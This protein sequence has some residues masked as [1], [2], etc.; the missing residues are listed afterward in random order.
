MSVNVAFDGNT[1]PVPNQPGE[2][3]WANLTAYLVALG[4]SAAT[5][6]A[7]LQAVRVATT[8]PVT[9]TATD[10]SIITNLTVA[11]AVAVDLP[12]GVTKQLI[13]IVDGKGD[14]QAN[15]VTITGNGGQQING[16]ANHVLNVNRGGV[17]LQFDGTQWRILAAFYGSTP[18]FTSITITSLNVTG[19]STL[20]AVDATSINIGGVSAATTANVS[21]A[22]TAHLSDPDPHSQYSTTAETSTAVAAGISAH[23]GASDPHPQYTTASEAAAAAPVQSVATRTGNVTLDKNDV[24]LSNVD[25]TSDATKNSATA[26]LSNKTL[27]S[28]TVNTPVLGSFEDWTHTTTP[29]N[30]SAGRLRAY[31]K[32]DGKPYVL[33]S[34]GVEKALLRA[35]DGG[36]GDVVGPSSTDDNAVVVW[37]GTTGKL[38]K[39]VTNGAF[40]FANTFQQTAPSGAAAA[41]DARSGA[42]RSYFGYVDASSGRGFIGNSDG[43]LTANNVFSIGFGAITDGIFAEEALQANSLG[44]VRLGKL[45]SIGGNTFP[46]HRFV[47]GTDST[48]PGVGYVDEY[49]EQPITSG[50]NNT[51]AAFGTQDS[52][53]FITL[54]AGRWEIGFQCTLW[55]YAGVSLGNLSWCGTMYLIDNGGNPLTHASFGVAFKDQQIFVP[56]ITT[57]QII[58]ITNSIQI[59]LRLQVN[60]TRDN[61]GAYVD[62]YANGTNLSGGAIPVRN[63]IYARRLL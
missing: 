54:Q 31:A 32:A 6:S 24:G 4:E 26:T 23:E 53:E 51:A 38:V 16:A 47:G 37:D 1:Y 59:R 62:C 36:T 14:A 55:C 13:A 27:S 57:R 18:S 45:T 2:S 63:Y 52:T 11:G 34:A 41:F 19:T 29:S 20:G 48:V 46:G 17:L 35:G 22:M 3:G 43:A 56:S 25:N 42:S 44:S 21:A 49:K 39:R 30:P 61:N 28:P 10:F 58:K 9:V 12:A 60:T 33:D 8:S 5:R 7:L 15:N 40:S 50:F